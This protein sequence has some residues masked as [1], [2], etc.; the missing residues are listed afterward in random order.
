MNKI[1]E[2]LE[3]IVENVPSKDRRGDNDRVKACID[4]GL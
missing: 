3:E 4:H 2:R 1:I